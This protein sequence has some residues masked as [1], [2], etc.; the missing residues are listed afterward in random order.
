MRRRLSVKVSNA[1]VVVLALGV[2]RTAPRVF[3]SGG[4]L[5]CGDQSHCRSARAFISVGLIFASRYRSAGK[6]VAH[7]TPSERSCA[8]PDL[9]GGCHADVAQSCRRH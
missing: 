5:R 2:K 8:G 9:S 7:L 3:A 1:S 4:S 6:P